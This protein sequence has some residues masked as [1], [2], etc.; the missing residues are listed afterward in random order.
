MKHLIYALP[1][2]CLLLPSP[3]LA[4]INAWAEHD[5]RVVQIFTHAPLNPRYRCNFNILVTFAD[6]TQHNEGG[7]TI[8]QPGGQP[9]ISYRGEF[10]KNIS[11]VRLTQWSCSPT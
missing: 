1:A 5:G 3:A 7:S 10:N 11:Q 2:A 9:G 6:G 4:Q 8:A